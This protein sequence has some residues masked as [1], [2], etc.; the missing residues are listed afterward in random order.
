MIVSQPTHIAFDRRHSLVGLACEFPAIA[1]TAEKVV[2]ASCAHDVDLVDA[3]TRQINNA[4]RPAVRMLRQ[5]T[6]HRRRSCQGGRFAA[7]GYSI[8]NIL[9]TRWTA[10]H[11]RIE[12]GEG[13]DHFVGIGQQRLELHAVGF[14]LFRFL[15]GVREERAQLRISSL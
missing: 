13:P 11:S 1:S 9:A 8:P 14:V 15:L 10:C 5:E 2:G 7:P 4:R 6:A 3:A 12:D